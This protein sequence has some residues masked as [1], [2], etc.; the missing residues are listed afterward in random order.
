MKSEF[1]S[2]VEDK[3]DK[4]MNHGDPAVERDFGRKLYPWRN[5][6]AAESTPASE[7]LAHSHA[8]RARRDITPVNNKPRIFVY[9]RSTQNLP[10]PSHIYIR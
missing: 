9:H 7:R 1:K 2:M 10:P 4:R 5:T 6:F 3:F 8:A